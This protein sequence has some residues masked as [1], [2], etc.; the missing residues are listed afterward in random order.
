MRNIFRLLG[1][2]AL[3]FVLCGCIENDIP[4]PVIKLD[5]V[6]IEAEGLKSAPAINAQDHTVELELKETADIRK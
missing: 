4:Y 6:S 5:I 2:G 3:M 1:M